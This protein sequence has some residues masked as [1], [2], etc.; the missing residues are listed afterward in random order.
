MT[1][2]VCLATSGTNYTLTHGQYDGRKNPSATPLR[3]SRLWIVYCHIAIFKHWDL[4][5]VCVLSHRNI[6]TLGP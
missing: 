4:K 3:K 6:Q 5:V 1:E 2:L